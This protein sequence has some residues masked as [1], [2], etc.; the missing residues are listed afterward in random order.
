MWSEQGTV[1]Q[2]PFGNQ[3]VTAEICTNV[4]KGL[5]SGNAAEKPGAM[6][7]SG[8]YYYSPINKQNTYLLGENDA[9]QIQLISQ[10]P[11]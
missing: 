11:V 9:P 7:N 3:A 10:P 5:S 1:S 6:T 2:H 8:D 4:G